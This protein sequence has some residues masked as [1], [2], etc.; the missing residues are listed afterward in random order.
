[1]KRK[2]SILKILRRSLVLAC[3]LSLFSMTALAEASVTYEPAKKPKVVYFL[4]D[5]TE[6]EAG[7]TVTLTWYVLNAAKVEIT[8]IEKVAECEWPLMGKAEVQPER[9]TTYVL[10]ATGAGG[11]TS[12]TVTV[13]VKE[14]ATPAVINFF[15]V[16]E[17]EIL[18]GESVTLS[19]DVSDAV[20]V[21]LNSSEVKAKGSMEV[22]P[23]VTTTYVLEAVGTDGKP[24]SKSVTVT[25]IER[26][27]AVIKSFTASE[28]EIA[29]G[30]SVTLSW[31]VEDAVSVTLN[32]VKVNSKGSMEVNPK[33]TTTYV[34]KA[35]GTD[36]VEVTE[37]VKVTVI[38]APVIKSFTASATTVEKGELVILRWNAE[39]ATYCEI[40]TNDGL[41]LA[42]RPA[43]GEIAI[44]PNNTKTYTLIAYNAKNVTAKASLTITV[45]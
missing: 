5:K 42:S 14:K 19:W 8:G 36:G 6:I 4:A 21:T 3:I 24:V 12:A 37:S 1:M 38:P 44:T 41:K 43:S 40:V 31:V 35:V 39:N 27:P 26:T 45:E 32:D 10:T 25:V 2:D 7:E 20:T 29:E 34:L 16:S 9:T 11:T 18:E 33:E 30:E 22:T 28:D 15:T 17:N 13:N 23:E